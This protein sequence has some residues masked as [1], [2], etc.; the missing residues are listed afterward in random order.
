MSR[1]SLHSF[2]CVTSARDDPGA[3]AGDSA[4]AARGAGAVV[5]GRRQDEDMSPDEQARRAKV[6]A[7]ARERQ[8]EHRAGC[9]PDG[10]TRASAAALSLLLHRLSVSFSRDRFRDD[11]EVA[12]VGA[13]WSKERVV[14]RCDGRRVGTGTRKTNAVSRMNGGREKRNRMETRLNSQPFYVS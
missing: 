2:F 14:S 5:L 3:A 6:C 4:A 8:R 10:P 7:A 1:P 9:P 11:G 13:V 12:L